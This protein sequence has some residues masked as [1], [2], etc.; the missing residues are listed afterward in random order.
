MPGN[1]SLLN[2]IEKQLLFILIKSKNL[3]IEKNMRFFII[4]LINYI[5]RK[6]N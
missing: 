6:N 2:M 5:T 1:N 4:W 3:H